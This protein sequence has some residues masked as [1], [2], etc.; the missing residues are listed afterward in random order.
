MR[1]GLKA[2]L[3]AFGGVT[4]ALLAVWGLSANTERLNVIERVMA[5]GIMG[6]GAL[7]TLVGLLF[8][9][10]AVVLV[11]GLWVWLIQARHRR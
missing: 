6:R 1:N 5:G 10:L 9:A 7:G 3:G 8:W 11:V 2:L 4:L